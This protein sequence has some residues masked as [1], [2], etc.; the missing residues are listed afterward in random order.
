MAKKP[1]KRERETQVTRVCTRAIQYLQI[2]IMDLS[3][4]RACAERALGL[5]EH[6][7]LR[8]EEQA[9]AVVREY[10]LTIAYVEPTKGTRHVG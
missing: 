8:T 7:N 10:A 6:G 3:K 9:I 5:D 4:V 2:N 1:T